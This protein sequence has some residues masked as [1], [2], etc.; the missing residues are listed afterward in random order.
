MLAG[1]AGWVGCA[2]WLGTYHLCFVTSMLQHT[3]YTI[4]ITCG[5]VLHTASLH[6]PNS[7]AG[8]T[9]MQDYTTPTG[10]HHLLSGARSRLSCWAVAPMPVKA[11]II[12]R[13]MSRA[14]ARALDLWSRALHSLFATR[15][16]S[17]SLTAAI[18]DSSFSKCVGPTSSSSLLGRVGRYRMQSNA[19][20]LHDT[21]RA[22]RARASRHAGPLARA[23]TFPSSWCLSC[24][25]TRLEQHIRRGARCTKKVCL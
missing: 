19:P 2:G 6:S 4:C 3:F 11:A 16:W 7:H 20:A 5:P 21:I 23:H 14:A 22:A 13:S 8:Y 10:T 1:L 15:A 9:S 17:C 12:S 25:S 18:S 24:C